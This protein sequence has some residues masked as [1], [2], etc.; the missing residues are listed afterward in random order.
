MKND[1]ARFWIK[2][3]KLYSTISKPRRA[4]VMINQHK[5]H[6]IVSQSLVV[7]MTKM[8]TDVMKTEK[9]IV[10]MLQQVET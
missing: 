7:V 3:S 5:K 2:Y 10:R 4:W 6:S 8:F 9:V 1:T